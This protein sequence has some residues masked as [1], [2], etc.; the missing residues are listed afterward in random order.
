MTL[1]VL[2]VIEG[3]IAEGPL[4]N[5]QHNPI[6]HPESEVKLQFPEHL[7]AQNFIKTHCQKHPLVNVHPSVRLSFMKWYYYAIFPT[8][9]FNKTS[10]VFIVG[11]G[12]E[13]RGTKNH[14]WISILLNSP[15]TSREVPCRLSMQ[16]N[17]ELFHL[18]IEKKLCQEPIMSVLYPC[19][20]SGSRPDSPQDRRKRSREREVMVEVSVYHE[21]LIGWHRSDRSERLGPRG[22]AG[23]VEM[24]SVLFHQHCE[25]W[26]RFMF[27]RHLAWGSYICSRRNG[28]FYW[29]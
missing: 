29:W 5:Y 25:E 10:H 11:G 13:C 12:G 6:T 16:V 28:S 14:P 15:V 18:N 20:V 8:C 17:F 2:I 9:S 21:V 22:T 19:A 24:A 26:N 1:S 23:E 27:C 7:L 4:P 3:G